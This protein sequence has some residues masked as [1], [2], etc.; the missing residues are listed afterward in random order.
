MENTD[1]DLTQ[2][3]SVFTESSTRKYTLCIRNKSVKTGTGTERPS[4]NNSMMQIMRK[5]AVDKKQICL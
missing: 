1:Y 5:S 2:R 3:F 4:T